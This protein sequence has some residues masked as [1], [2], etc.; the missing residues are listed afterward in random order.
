MKLYQT[1]MTIVTYTGV[2][3]KQLKKICTE[4]IL[5]KEDITAMQNSYL[6]LFK[7]LYK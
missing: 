3:S 2:Q 6:A 7:E 4:E 5:S 1:N